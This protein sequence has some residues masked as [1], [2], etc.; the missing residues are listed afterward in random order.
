MFRFLT[1]SAAF[2]KIFA[3]SLFTFLAALVALFWDSEDG[4]GRGL[5]NLEGSSSKK[6]WSNMFG[7]MYPVR[8]VP[9]PC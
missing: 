1:R 6:G 7:E 3:R 8:L 2:V 5:G 9:P 4:E